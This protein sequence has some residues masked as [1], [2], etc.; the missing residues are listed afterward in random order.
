M[1][2]LKNV[3]FVL[4][5]LLVFAHPCVAFADY[6]IYMDGEQLQFDVAP[7]KKNDTYF[8]PIRTIAETLG[9]SVTYSSGKIYITNSDM[10][11]KINLTLGDKQAVVQGQDGAP[12]TY[13]LAAAPYIKNNRTMLPLRFLAE[14]LY[15][16]VEYRPGVIKIII[17][18][19][20]IDGQAIYTMEI[21]NWARTGRKHLVNTCIAM[22]EECR[23]EE[24]DAPE[25]VKC[26]PYYADY[27]FYN[28]KGELVASWCFWIPDDSQNMFYSDTVYL[29]NVLTGQYYKADES[30][31][32]YYFADDGRQLELEIAAY[33]GPKRPIYD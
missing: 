30:V 4:F 17:P 14:Q 25:G 12:I 3:C 23:R 32:E 26:D 9:F 18:G 16:N 24:I 10:G 27:R 8:V 20:I 6:P 5:A 7:E 11:V 28:R 2:A 13:Q 29:Q 22:L 31:V 1:R 15:C 33:M 21:K 19:D